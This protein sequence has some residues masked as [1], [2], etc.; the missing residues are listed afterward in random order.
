M[1]PLVA[2]NEDVLR[3]LF[4]ILEPP[5]AR[6][7]SCASRAMHILA[8]PCSLSEVDLGSYSW[9]SRNG[10]SVMDVVGYLLAPEPFLLQPRLT[11]LTK[12]FLPR[13]RFRVFIGEEEI[14][15]ALDLALVELLSQA[16]FIRTLEVPNVARYVH[17][18]S[19]IFD[20]IPRLQHLTTLILSDVVPG[21]LSQLR[22]S[23]HLLSS[24][25]S[26]HLFLHNNTF[27]N[28]F[29]SPAGDS[30]YHFINSL[31]RLRRLSHL[32]LRGD[33]SCY[34]QA[35]D[36]SELRPLEPL[37]FLRHLELV[38]WQP[39]WVPPCPQLEHLSLR[40]LYDT[41]VLVVQPFPT[42]RVIDFEFDE[43]EEGV[44]P[45]ISKEISIRHVDHLR[46]QGPIAVDTKLRSEATDE[47]RLDL[48]LDRIQSISAFSMGTV[49]YWHDVEDQVA[50]DAVLACAVSLG[51]RSLH[52]TSLAPEVQSASAFG[53]LL[54]CLP[55]SLSTIPLLHLGI[56][57]APTWFSWTEDASEDTDVP[58]PVQTTYDTLPRA[59]VDSIPTLRVLKIEIKRPREGEGAVR[60]RWQRWWWIE[61]MGERAEMV[62]LWR[63][64]GERA[65]EL[66]EDRGFDREKSL[67]G[68]LTPKRV[69]QP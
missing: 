35:L 59:L 60:M 54:S 47:F 30:I 53:I 55:V 13:I 63:E 25:R 61:R 16:V 67:D 11:Y 31:S 2:L 20:A 28:S 66:I 42:L 10:K 36:R 57:L 44:F 52:V 48:F 29:L 26:L 56:T 27:P 40:D 41:D 7:A 46:I 38:A 37:P 23:L 24:L 39:V 22:P 21:A 33:P 45:T 12:L 69:Y 62:E 32:L 5:D 65:C 4:D 6:R 15:Q 51:I 1:P 58:P 14:R 19:R 8:R 49:Y 9:P 3:Y 34:S 18:E 43:S 64:D 68:F 17:R 50:P